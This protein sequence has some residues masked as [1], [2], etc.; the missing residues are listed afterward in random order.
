MRHPLEF[1]IT[2]D[3]FADLVGVTQQSVSRLINEGVLLR[4][5]TG[6]DWLKA[7]V[8][9]LREQAT[10]RLGVEQGLDLVQE[11]AWLAREQRESYRIRNAVA[12][13]EY[14]PIGLLAHVLAAASTAI[15]ERIDSLPGVLWKACP[16]LPDEARDAIGRVLNSARGE[17]IRG[18]SALALTRC[19]EVDADNLTLADEMDDPSCE[20]YPRDT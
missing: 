19:E 20:D 18:T 8:E 12:L 5:G 10:G 1:P 6:V 14:A 13:G 4:E 3:E 7:Y 15:V 16:D 11:R 17:W 9:R 2:Q